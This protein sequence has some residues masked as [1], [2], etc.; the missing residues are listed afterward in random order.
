MNA[1]TNIN[2]MKDRK[3]RSYHYCRCLKLKENKNIKEDLTHKYS[4]VY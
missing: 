4:F 3:P 2:T 1:I